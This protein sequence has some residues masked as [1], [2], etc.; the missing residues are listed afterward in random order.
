MLSV[1]ATEE[2]TQ[3]EASIEIKPSYGLTDVEIETM[4]RDSITHAQGDVE[5]RNVREQ[6][7]EADRVIDAL[8]IA[9]QQD[10]GWQW[11][12][13]LVDRLN[14]LIARG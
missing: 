13:V 14:Y 11:F 3:A 9:L 4:L 8:Q 10:G 12:F 5:A 2:S 6:Q 1:T 7:V